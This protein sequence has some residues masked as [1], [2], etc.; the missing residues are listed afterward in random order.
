MIFTSLAGLD[1]ITAM[2]MNGF[3]TLKQISKRMHRKD[4]VA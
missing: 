2:S 3:N 1:D 4:I